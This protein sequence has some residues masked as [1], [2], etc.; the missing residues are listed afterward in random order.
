MKR[1]AK[2]M[3]RF[4]LVGGS[5]VIVNMAALAVFYDGFGLGLALA[6]ALAIQIAIITNFIGH[7][8]FTFVGSSGSIIRR[9][10]SF[11]L[12]SLATATITW[13]ILNGLAFAFGA[14]PAYIVYVYNLI[15][16]GIGFIANYLLNASS[17]W[18]DAY[19]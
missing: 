8:L 6:S 18:K 19:A 13:I 10:I 15:A 9:F 4:A 7:H 12:I 1:H 5:G 3:M 11:E 17:T 16:I 2:R 14:E